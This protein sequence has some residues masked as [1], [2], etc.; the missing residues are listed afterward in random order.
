MLKVQGFEKAQGTA[1]AGAGAPPVNSLS[2]MVGSSASSSSAAV[3]TASAMDALEQA[4][5]RAGEKRKLEAYDDEG[6]GEDVRK[7]SRMDADEIDI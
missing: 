1:G 2:G 5:L 7:E 3:A 6:E 4:A